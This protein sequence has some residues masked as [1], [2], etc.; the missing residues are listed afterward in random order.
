MDWSDQ[1]LRKVK[2]NVAQHVLWSRSTREY[3]SEP[4]F[5]IQS[6]EAMSREVRQSETELQKVDIVFVEVC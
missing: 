3:Q 1:S 2:P 5:K 6:L 4:W